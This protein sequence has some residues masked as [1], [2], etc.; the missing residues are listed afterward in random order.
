MRGCRTARARLLA[1]CD[2]ELALEER[3]LLDAHLSRCAR[4]TREERRLLALGELLEGAL[5][6]TP[7]PP[8]LEAAHRAVFAALDRGEGRPW[9]PAL[10]ARRAAL[11]GSVAALLLAASWLATRHVSRPTLASAPVEETPVAAADAWT[12]ER[13][14]LAVRQALLDVIVDGE[15]EGG[16]AERFLAEL[17]EPARAGW[18]VRRFV[19]TQLEHP[20]PDV[21]RRAARCLGLLEDAGAVP[22]LERALAR[23]EIAEASLAALAD[24]GEPAVGTLER[25]LA[26]PALAQ[27]SL[28]ALCRIGGER[29]ARVLERR[30]RSN[31]SAVPSRQALLD[32][33]TTTGRAAAD[34]LLRLAESE[35]APGE[36]DAILARL[37]LVADADE[38]LDLALARGRLDADV[39]YRA[40]ALLQPPGGLAWLEERCGEHRERERAIDVLA[41]YTGRGP[42]GVALRLAS[43]GRV[44]RED[45]LDL[46][47]RLLERDPPR[48]ESFSD[49]L[50][51]R[52]DPV[53]LREW[54]LLLIDSEHPDAAPVLARLAGCELLAADDRQWAAL[55]VGELGRP[56]DAD[57]LLE[58]LAKS[59]AGDRRRAAACLLSAH[60]LAGTDGVARFL[61]GLSPAGQRRVLAV[62]EER[63]RGEAVLLHRVARALDA[64]AAEATPDH[65]NLIL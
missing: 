25:A 19:E 45:A 8:D 53:A 46:L 48:A 6:H 59:T 34:S 14:E 60:A 54:L 10:R 20:D 41:G 50:A 52:G 37:V 40:V 12:E 42:L 11:L 22:A 16:V 57:R 51:G 65:G 33:L 15:L 21:A 64:A 13:V 24:L 30:I 29:A 17:R 49:D 9:R 43:T 2:R 27:P 7:P 36:R 32:A 63:G 4:C 56:A 3:F 55:A 35:P 18:P 62:L 28:R 31:A 61:G 58:L 1:A 39:A 38:E 23:T 47:A 26:E 44:P 5:D